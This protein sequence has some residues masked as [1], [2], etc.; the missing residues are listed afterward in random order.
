MNFSI[1]SD[2][3]SAT[4]KVA[5]IALLILALLIPVGMVKSVAY[6]R[7]QIAAAA[8]IDI[9]NSWGGHQTV[10]GP[11]LRLPFKVEATT[12]HG[13]PYLADRYALL[14][15]DDLTGSASVSVEKRYRGIHEVPVFTTDLDMEVRF[16]LGLLEALDLDSESIIWSDAELLIGM[17]D[18]AAMNEI[19]LSSS[20]D[21]ES[22]FSGTARQ[23]AG[24]PSQLSANAGKQLQDRPDPTSFRT[25]ISL[26]FNG[27][28]ALQFL[29]LAEH[30][31]VK[32]S[33]NWP[34]PSFTG[35][36]LPAV[37]EVSED[38]FEALWKSTSI[39]RNLP[40]IWI[41]GEARP[42]MELDGIFGVRFILP[43]GLYQLMDRALKYAIMFIGLTFV[44]YFLMETVARVRLHP[45]QYFLV[46]LANTLFYLLLLSLAEHIGFGLAYIASA[47]SSAAL[48]VGYSSTV[49]HNKQRTLVMAAVLLGL[50]CFLYLTL[51][52]ERYALVAG[53]V[54]LW[55]ILGVIMYLTRK[56][57]WYSTTELVATK[58]EQDDQGSPM[59]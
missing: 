15:A 3:R 49:L 24:L 40:P 1:S 23:I 33:A 55:V 57:D 16:D 48:I 26:S 14:V 42:N 22:E 38:G 47:F 21:I 52:A 44:T 34:S 25:K 50:Y 10:A 45:L 11:I 58:D 51:M 6:D 13:V 53:S 56:I 20:G 59:A 4:V 31:S 54:G 27:S 17:S 37:R 36:R 30:S 9:R 8:A 5:A 43:I 7:I 35:R 29:P 19:P 39:G 46:G 28:E 41:E 12:A 32:T 18:P 2:R